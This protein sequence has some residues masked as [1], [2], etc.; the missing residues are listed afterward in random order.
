MNR[1]DSEGN[2]GFWVVVGITLAASVMGAASQLIVNS[3]CGAKGK[4]L[5]RNV[6]GAAIGAI[7][8]GIGS[9]ISN[10]LFNSKRKCPSFKPV[11]I[12][13]KERDINMSCKIKDEIIIKYP[14]ISKADCTF[15][16][17]HVGGNNYIIFWDEIITKKN[18]INIKM[19]PVK[20]TVKKGQYN[21]N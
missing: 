1:T 5:L 13:Y 8:S 12:G 18:K 4:D 7:Y 17:Y 16:C 14:L 9:L 21:A 19:Y 11:Y 15:D 6:T 3:I 10:K 20:R 2:F